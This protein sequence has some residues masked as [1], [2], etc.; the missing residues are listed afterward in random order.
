LQPKQI[1]PV[2][3]ASYPYWKLNGN[4]LPKDE[5]A[6]HM[7]ALWDDLSKVDDYDA[8]K[9][10]FHRERIS[11]NDQLSMPAPNPGLKAAGP[12]SITPDDRAAQLAKAMRTPI[13]AEK[14]MRSQVMLRDDADEGWK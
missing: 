4:P 3:R 13:A 1:A 10:R 5:I 2:E 12:S 7:H 8:A 6:R 9:L 14:T 11:R